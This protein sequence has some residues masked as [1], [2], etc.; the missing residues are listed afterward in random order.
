M[1][2]SFAGRTHSTMVSLKSGW[3]VVALILGLSGM[4]ASSHFRGGIIQW[5]PVNAQNFDGRVRN[6]LNFV[7]MQIFLKKKKKI[8]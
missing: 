5:R 7:S 8:S 6:K 1:G 4:A 3:I 2:H